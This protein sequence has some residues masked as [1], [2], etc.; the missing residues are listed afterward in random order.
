ML[1]TSSFVDI[2]FAHNWPG[3]TMKLAYIHSDS[4][5]GHHWWQSVLYKIALLSVV[6]HYSTL[7]V[8]CF[9]CAVNVRVLDFLSHCKGSR[10]P[11]LRGG[12]S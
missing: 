5:L 3:T 8:T 4:L 9:S 7:K 6:N 1:C 12:S 2:I 10:G 11:S